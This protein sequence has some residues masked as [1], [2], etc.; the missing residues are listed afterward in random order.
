[1]AKTEKSYTGWYFLLVV[2]VLSTIIFTIMPE[3]LSELL[4]YFLSLVKNILPTLI[5]VF[6]L[7]F[8]INLFITKEWI[9]KNFQKKRGWFFSIVAGI[10]S[11]G[12]IYL[13]YPLLSELQDKGIRNA[14]LATFIY[15]R[16][17]K[18]A[19][20]PLIIFYFGLAFTVIL[21]IV[22]VFASI[23][24]GIIVEKIVNK[25]EVN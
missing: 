9:L 22:M 5:L 13:W 3:K 17:V 8:I 23:V 21:T 7:M 2:L 24:Q 16:A 6:V 25:M 1:M 20:L 14:Y 12:P 19:L 4:A 15:N 18:P 10:L 11:V